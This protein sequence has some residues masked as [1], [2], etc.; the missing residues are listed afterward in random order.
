MTQP[1]A[2]LVIEDIRARERKGVE[3][4][5]TKLY[6]N[7]GRDALVD[8]YEE[9]IDAVKYLRQVIEERR[10]Q[11]PTDGNEGASSTP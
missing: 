3:T 7:N 10:L 9:L 11:S 4:Y 5:G 1:I 2:D 6:A 8:L